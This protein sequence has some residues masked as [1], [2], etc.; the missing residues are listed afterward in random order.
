MELAHLVPHVRQVLKP[1]R[2]TE[3]LVMHIH[4]LVFVVTGVQVVHGVL[5]DVQSLVARCFQVVLRRQVRPEGARQASVVAHVATLQRFKKKHSFRS[6]TVALGL[7]SPSASKTPT[8]NINNCKHAQT[9]E[10]TAQH[11]LCFKSFLMM[12]VFLATLLAVFHVQTLTRSVA[13]S[14]GGALVNAL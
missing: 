9:H 7:Q 3:H 13:F 14:C 5:Y 6:Q 8:Q 2:R 10:N 11:L 4:D 12:L 1:H